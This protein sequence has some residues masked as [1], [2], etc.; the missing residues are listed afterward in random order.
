M[1]G[2]TSIRQPR[3]PRY[4][5]TAGGCSPGASWRRT[6]RRSSSSS[7]ACAGRFT[8]PSRWALLGAR[9]PVDTPDGPS[10]IAGAEV[11]GV[12]LAAQA[13]GGALLSGG[14]PGNVV[15]GRAAADRRRVRAERSE[16]INDA[17]TGSY[18]EAID[19]H[20]PVGGGGRRRVAGSA[21]QTAVKTAVG[22]VGWEAGFP[23]L[24]RAPPWGCATN[25]TPAT[26]GT[27]I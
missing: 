13:H 3:W 5:M 6:G 18:R 8:W 9:T 27:A 1:W 24:F 10:F 12:E 4:G 26:S 19:D 15:G 21:R 2:L 22:F 14:K 7:A 16:A 20:G 11:G 17:V 25:S 23:P